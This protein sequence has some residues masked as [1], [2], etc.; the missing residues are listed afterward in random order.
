LKY[1]TQNHFLSSNRGPIPSK[2]VKLVK[3]PRSGVANMLSKQ[4]GPYPFLP[5]HQPLV[6]SLSV[7]HS[8][9][10]P[11][12]ALE[13][14]NL[15]R[16]VHAPL[17]YG[18]QHCLGGYAVAVLVEGEQEMQAALLHLRSLRVLRPGRERRRGEEESLLKRWPHL[19]TTLPQ[20]ATL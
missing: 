12:V 13:N 6:K 17:P 7:P 20:A 11:R 3:D 18:S 9:I 2:I 5:E 19:S 8:R 10:E 15:H 1:R 4:P 14:L 16:R